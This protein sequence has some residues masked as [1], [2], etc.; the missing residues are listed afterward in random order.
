[1]LAQLDLDCLDD[2]LVVPPPAL[3][4]RHKAERALP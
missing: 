2:L 1:M 4:H 3:L